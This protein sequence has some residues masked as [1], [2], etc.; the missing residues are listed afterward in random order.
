MILN[1]TFK[2]LLEIISLIVGWCFCLGHGSQPLIKWLKHKNLTTKKGLL[3]G[4]WQ[5]LA[6]SLGSMIPELITNQGFWTL[7]KWHLWYE[8]LDW[9]C[10]VSMCFKDTY[11]IWLVHVPCLG[12]DLDMPMWM[13]HALVKHLPICRSVSLSV[14]DLLTIANKHYKHLCDRNEIFLRYKN[15]V[16]KIPKKW[17]TIKLPLSISIALS[18]K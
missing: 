9:Y 2:Y 12:C 7:L 16:A 17:G 1:I 8:I 18:R 14:C 4:T 15:H 5:A 11:L 3:S 13:S 10:P 6:F